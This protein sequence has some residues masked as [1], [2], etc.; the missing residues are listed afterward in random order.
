MIGLPP[1]PEE[2]DEFAK[3]HGVNPQSAIEKAVERLLASPHYGE[4]RGRLWLDVAR[5]GEDQ[6]FIV[7]SNASLNYPNAYLYRDWVIDAFNKDMPFDR[8]VQMQLAA[9]L[10]VPKE[11]SQ[12][13]ALGFIG[14]GPKYYD[15]GR[16]SVM[17]DEWED[18]VDIIGRGLLGLTLACARCHD[19]KYDPIPT[20]DY[21]GLAGVFASTKMWN[22]PLDDKVDKKDK[23]DEAKEPKNA[24]HII[25]DGASTDLNV[26]VRGNVD[27]KGPVEKRHFLHVLCAGEPKPFKIGSG[28]QE[29]AEAI[30]SSANP[31][32]A[33]VIVNRIWAAH[34]GKGIVGTTSN[35]GTQ[36]DPPSHPELLDD[37]AVRF[38]ENGWSLKW[39]HRE[40]VLSATYRQSCDVTARKKTI[41][42]DNRLLSRMSRQKLSVESSRD[43]M[44]AAAGTLD[45]T[46]GGKSIDPLDPKQ[47]RRTV[48]SAVS[49]LDLNRLL[50]LFDFPDPNIHASRRVETTTPLQKLFVLNSP[51]MIAHAEALTNRLMHDVAGTD[52]DTDRRR[53]DRAY[54]LL[55]CRPAE[56][57]EI[58]IGLKYLARDGDRNANW[59]HYAHALLA[60]NELMFVD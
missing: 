60:A 20:T 7:G 33:R 8:F 51:F 2:V 38:V 10:I 11:P 40:I 12:L 19:H 42:A 14:L 26:F 18:R 22:K 3:D 27:S 53:I 4:R 56:D 43:S 49:R 57:K 41:D 24:L 1:S 44:L 15:R 6:A 5:Y 28:R 45:L 47:H 52:P 59:K 34:F 25:K 36:G 46:V 35:F 32:T 58:A 16:L 54:R 50:A 31:L 55:Y 23:S 21:H 13:P 39:L 37:L 29:L 17:A 9:D 48:Y 30:A